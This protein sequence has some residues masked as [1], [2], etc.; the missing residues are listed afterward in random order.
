M[1]KYRKILQGLPSF[2]AGAAPR[3]E[4]WL[5]LVPVPPTLSMKGATHEDDRSIEGRL[6]L[7]VTTHLAYYRDNSVMT[8]RCGAF[9]CDLIRLVRFSCIVLRM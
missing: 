6:P 3:F 1:T 8:Q 7:R 5:L 4:V 2:P 9:L